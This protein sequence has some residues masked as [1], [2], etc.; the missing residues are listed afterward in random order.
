GTFF[1]LI[2]KFF[3]GTRATLAAPWFDRYTTPL[4]VLLVLFTGIGPLFAWRKISPSGLRR[5]MVG[6]LLAA[7]TVALVLVAATDVI[8]N[9]WA[10]AVFVLAAFTVVALAQE[11]LRSA[12]ARKG[13]SGE[14]LVR[15][16][17]TV[18]LGNRRR[19]GGYLV[20]LGFVL[21]LV[22]VAASSSFETKRDV[23][24]MPGESAQVEDFR[25][26]YER[27]TVSRDDQ[28]LT[29]GAMLRV[30]STDG[31]GRSIVLEPTRRYFL[32]GSGTRSIGGYFEGEATSEVGLDAWGLEDFWVALEPDTER[33]QERA[34]SADRRFALYMR[35]VVLPAV[36]SQPGRAEEL[37]SQLVSIQDLAT[38][39]VIAD[40]TRPAFATPATFR[41]IVSPVVTAV[42]IGAIVAV[43]GALFALWPDR[44]RRREE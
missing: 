30:D 2:S 19:Y 23:T 14:G 28:A 32:R 16:I 22:G 25:V 5:M 6:P 44:R 41:V 40:Y 9:P 13:A 21:L 35:S 3:T 42:W 26:T 24:L 18:T 39:R 27:P 20:H 10:F 15:S 36:Q 29:F 34:K 4:A 11:T 33:I 31:Q 1:P 43:L 8:D 7:L 12:A 17:G 37:T 38:D